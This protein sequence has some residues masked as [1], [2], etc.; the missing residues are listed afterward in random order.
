MTSECVTERVLR[1]AGTHIYSFIGK[2]F[3]YVSL[4]S[5]CL[6]KHLTAAGPP[7]S[8]T[9]ET[10]IK[11]D[12][13]F[14]L[15]TQNRLLNLDDLQ[16][17]GQFDSHKVLSKLLTIIGLG[18]ATMHTQD[19]IY[20]IRSMLQTAKKNKSR[21]VMQV[22]YNHAASLKPATCE[23]HTRQHA[24]MHAW[25]KD[26]EAILNAEIVYSDKTKQPPNCK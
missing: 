22:L 15:S 17:I 7:E 19:F 1:V 2:Y 11:R 23:Y 3:L 8:W 6:Y 26:A 5:P 14:A 13:A 25:F 10:I 4:I 24:A 12:D 16:T 18:S 21:N 20:F 9:I